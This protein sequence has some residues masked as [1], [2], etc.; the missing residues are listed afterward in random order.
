[1]SN[2]NLAAPFLRTV[3][4]LGISAWIGGGLGTALLLSLVLRATFENDLQAFNRAIEA[5]DDWII[6]PGAC[7]T[8]LSGLA[9]ARVR[10]LPVLG[11]A[12]L[13]LKL[14]STTVAIL[15]GFFFVAHWLERMHLYSVRDGLILFDDLLYARAYRIGAAGCAIQ[16]V[17]VLLLVAV[18]VLRPRF[19]KQ[20]EAD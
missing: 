18:S 10:R 12:W 11:T 9:L 19:R 3:H 6:A 5:I 4:L 7:T 13:R 1:M 15:F 20:S 8:L 14:V 2:R 16:A 17:V